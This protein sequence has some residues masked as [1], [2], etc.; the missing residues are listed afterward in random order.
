[1]IFVRKVTLIERLIA[2]LPVTALCFIGFMVYIYVYINNLAQ[3]DLTVLTSILI[4]LSAL[5]IFRP[6]IRNIF[7]SNDGFTVNKTS[8][9]PTPNEVIERRQKQID[10][11]A[12]YFGYIIFV[13]SAMYLVF[14][15]V[16]ALY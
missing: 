14:I 3:P 4:L 5:L 11:D 9:L 15:E 12:R 7:S 1:M 13:L 10:E 8:V 6:R 2:P 16:V